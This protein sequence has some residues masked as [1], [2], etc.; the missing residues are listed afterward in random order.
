M[1][2]CVYIER[3]NGPILGQKDPKETWRIIESK[4]FLGKTGVRSL[5]LFSKLAQLVNDWA[6]IYS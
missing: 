2:P 1:D 3:E 4:Y 6:K 5:R